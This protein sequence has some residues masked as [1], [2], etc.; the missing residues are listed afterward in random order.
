M[1]MA[2]Q[3]VFGFVVVTALI[4]ATVLSLHNSTWMGA[5]M[6]VLALVG[7]LVAGGAEVGQPKK[8]EGDKSRE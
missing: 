8:S 3:L 1:S 5:A 4:C 7:L 6:I 2:T